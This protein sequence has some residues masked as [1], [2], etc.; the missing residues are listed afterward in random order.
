MIASKNLGADSNEIQL[1]EDGSWSAHVLKSDTQALDT[2]VKSL[3]ANVEIIS[4]DLGEL[5]KLFPSNHFFLNFPVA[6]FPEVIS[7]K[8]ASSENAANN[9]GAAEPSST[10]GETV[11][12]LSK[13]VCH[14]TF[15]WIF[16]FGLGGFDIE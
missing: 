7:T 5:V 13:F 10:T 9:Q 8:C 14:Q 11:S 4:D 2:P 6:F 16:L 12:C 3:V 1:H 15:Q